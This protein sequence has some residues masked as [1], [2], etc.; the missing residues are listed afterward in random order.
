MVYLPLYRIQNTLNIP[1][2]I[3]KMVLPNNTK[4]PTLYVMITLEILNLEK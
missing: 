2:F 1:N 3:V 4:L